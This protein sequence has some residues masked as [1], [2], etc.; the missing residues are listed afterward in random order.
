MKIIEA[1]KKIK[2]LTRKADDLEKKVRDNCADLDC[3][4]AVYENQK[5]KVGEW[6]QS[7]GDIVKEILHLRV[8]IQKTNLET[9]V[10]IEIGEQF[11]TKSIAEWIHRRKDLAKLDERIWSQLGDRGLRETQTFKLTPA[12]PEAYVKIRRYYDAS[13]RDAKIA[14]Y[15]EEPSK[16]N[17]TLE[18]VNAV[19]DLK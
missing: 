15:R 16:I 10:T 1:L 19:T 8:R 7:H 18:I 6:L 9:P 11:L 5:L 12:S 2:D 4:T 17:A 14:L 3:E 13:I